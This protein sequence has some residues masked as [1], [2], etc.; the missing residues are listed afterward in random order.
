MRR[1]D[2]VGKLLRITLN[3]TQLKTGLEKPFFE[4]PFEIGTYLA[5][6]T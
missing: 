2:S 6:N 3:D 5:K 4:Y 1:N